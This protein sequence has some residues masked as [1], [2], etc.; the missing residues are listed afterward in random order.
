MDLSVLPGDEEFRPRRWA[1]RLGQPINE[2][3]A[4][5]VAEGSS[6]GPAG[7]IRLRAKLPGLEMGHNTTKA[8]S[9]TT[10][11]SPA[12]GRFSNRWCKD[13]ISCGSI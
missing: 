9:V 6:P 13:P 8:D 7:S 4:A 5:D 1:K 11:T 10:P 2:R 12:P 3:L